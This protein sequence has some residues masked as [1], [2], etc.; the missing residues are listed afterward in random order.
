MRLRV[1]YTAQLRTIVGRAEEVVELPEGSHL[2]DLVARLA[3]ELHREAAAHLLTEAGQLRPSL[4][5]AVNQTAVSPGMAH[6]TRL[7]EGDVVSLMPP[8]AGG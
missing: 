8:I 3:G 6:G 1:Q 7:T 5:V 4:L 2:A